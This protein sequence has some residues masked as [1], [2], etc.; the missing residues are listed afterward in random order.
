MNLACLIGVRP[1]SE[2]RRDLDSTGRVIISRRYGIVRGPVRP[3][4]TPL[5]QKSL[6]A[7]GDS[8]MAANWQP[9]RYFYAHYVLYS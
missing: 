6:A 9:C 3:P 7:G 8:N 4:H 1:K 5:T 2:H